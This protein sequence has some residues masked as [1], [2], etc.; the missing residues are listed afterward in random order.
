MLSNCLEYRSDFIQ[1]TATLCKKNTFQ[2]TKIMGATTSPATFFSQ[3][4]F[5]L[6]FELC[7]NMYQSWVCCII[8]CLNWKSVKN[9]YS[10]TYLLNLKSVK[11]CTVAHTYSTWKLW[12]VYG[13]HWEKIGQHFPSIFY[14]FYTSPTLNSTNKYHLLYKQTSDQFSLAHLWGWGPL[15]LSFP[16][17]LNCKL[18]TGMQK[19]KLHPELLM[20]HKGCRWTC[21][22][23]LP[24]PQALYQPGMVLNLGRPESLKWST[25]S[26]PLCNSQNSSQKCE[27]TKILAQHSQRVIWHP[28]SCNSYL[29]SL[30]TCTVEH[31]KMCT[32]EHLK[33][34]MVENLKTC[35][36]TSVFFLIS[37]ICEKYS[38][39]LHVNRA[40]EPHVNPNSFIC[41]TVSQIK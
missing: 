5:R 12:N 19:P 9:V 30:K 26:V 41:D 21:C 8:C 14:T 4:T 37:Y 13:N 3:Y 6:Q 39:M 28:Y 23:D 25:S 10:S 11:T 27:Q 16:F 31:V 22:S 20:Q 18:D 36:V 34:C 40:W 2:D 15:P 24:I 1:I 7:W 33:T 38:R 17:S 35:M 32:V 29:Q